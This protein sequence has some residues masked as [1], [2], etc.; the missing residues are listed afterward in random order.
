MRAQDY[1]FAIALVGITG[2]A[3]ISLLAFWLRLSKFGVVMLVVAMLASLAGGI[4]VHARF[5]SHRWKNRT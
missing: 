1:A 2:A 5:G 3:E 4:F